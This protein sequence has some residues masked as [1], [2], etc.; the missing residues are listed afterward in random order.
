MT[1]FHRGLARG[2]GDK[3]EHL[4]RASLALR[5]SP[6]YAHPFYWAGFVLVGNPYRSALVPASE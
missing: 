5:R 2:E 1:S 3:A 6:R 4:R